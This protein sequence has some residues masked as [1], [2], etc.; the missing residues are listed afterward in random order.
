[1]G[2]VG[3]GLA[4]AETFVVSNAIKLELAERDSHVEAYCQTVRNYGGDAGAG[5]RGAVSGLL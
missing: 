1:L 4:V 3:L 2:E 5:F